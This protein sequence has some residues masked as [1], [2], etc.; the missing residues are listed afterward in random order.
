MWEL[1][2]D[3]FRTPPWSSQWTVSLWEQFDKKKCTYFESVGYAPP[4]DLFDRRVNAQLV[5]ER[6]AAVSHAR[7]EQSAKGKDQGQQKQWAEEWARFV[8]CLL[9]RQR[10]EVFLE[11]MAEI[12]S[13]KMLA[14]W[15]EFSR[16]V[17]SQHLLWSD[18]RQLLEFYKDTV[19]PIAHTLEA[20]Q[21]KPPWLWIYRKIKRLYRNVLKLE[22]YKNRTQLLPK[23]HEFC[24]RRLAMAKLELTQIQASLQALTMQCGSIEGIVHQCTSAQHQQLLTQSAKHAMQLANVQQQHAMELA[25]VHQQHAMESAA[26]LAK[27]EAERQGP[28]QAMCIICT[29]ELPDIISMP[30]QHQVVC[31]SCFGPA[32]TDCPNCRERITAHVNAIQVPAILCNTGRWRLP[33]IVLQPCCHQVLCDTC[34]DAEGIPEQCPVCGADVG[35]YLKSFL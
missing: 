5:E 32:I 10:Y 28:E 21:I 23:I 20:W 8:R 35:H 9:Q 29:D 25:N 6:L 24:K 15:R 22:R 31:S 26:Q 34:A 30:C 2:E 4:G 17:L 3:Y 7:E 11:V 33:N 19:K 12:Q 1:R 27:V 16:F 13:M 14:Q 18:R